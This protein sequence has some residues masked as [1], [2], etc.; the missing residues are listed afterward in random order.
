M[1][2]TG[3]NQ[4]RRTIH[5]NNYVEVVEDNGSV[6]L[7]QHEPSVVVMPYTVDENGNPVSIGIISEISN[8]RPGGI[9]KTLITGSP[10][11]DDDN[12]LQTAIRELEEESGISAGDVKRWKFL[13]NIYTS[14]M[15]SN[16]NPCFSVDVTGLEIKEK[17]TDG[18]TDEKDSTFEML[19]ISDAL[20]LDDALVSTLFIKH[21][22]NN[23]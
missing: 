2:Q 22:K 20:S 8:S 12:I 11:D 15:V 13:G 4:S 9:A 5:S 6:Y 1:E 17:E 10:S 18:T 21:F 14:K 23:F 19:D 16:P 3:D 7:Q